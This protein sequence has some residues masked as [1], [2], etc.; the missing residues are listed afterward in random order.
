MNAKRF[1]AVV[2]AIGMITAAFVLRRNVIESDDAAATVPGTDAPAVSDRLV[3]ITELE[4]VCRAVGAAQPQ[5][6]IDI[7][8]GLA[9]L[10]RL[11]ALDDGDNVPLWLTVE[12]FPAMVDEIRTSEGRDPLGLG[13]E[14][15]A[16]TQLGIAAPV[17]GRFEQL[18]TACPDAPAWR[19]LGQQAGTP[20][21]EL[22]G[23]ENWGTVR[24]S[25]GSVD[26]SA[27]AL[28]SFAAAVAGYVGE[29]TFSRATWELDPD[30]I[31]WVR[32]LARTVPTERLSGGTPLAT[33]A[34]RPGALDMAAT[35]GAEVSTV[36]PESARFEVKYPEPAMS[37]EAV[38][39]VPTEGVQEAAGAA[40][41][42]L[43]EAGWSPPV[44][45]TSTL[46]SA[47]T[48]LALRTLWQEAT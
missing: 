41:T 21:T 32:R 35:T 12:P 33:M 6:D 10:D 8:D 18:A 36:D 22:G 34:T 44:D 13:S 31:G 27:V 40:T 11:A 29:P 19:C 17:G 47:T 25:V 5:L 9:T 48:M 37:L 26:R 15:L 28:A 4:A 23:Q 7:E 30:F 43:T 3:C 42:A 38:L 2:V 14:T 46:P 45:V 39:A 16:A 24:P 1:A 20:W